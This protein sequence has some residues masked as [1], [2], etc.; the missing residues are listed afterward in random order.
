M[1]KAVFLDRDGVINKIVYS[2]EFGIVDSPKN[3]AEFDLFDGVGEAVKFFKEI[4]FLVI[5]VSNQPGVAKGKMSLELLEEITKKMKRE[6]AQKGAYLDGVYYCLHHPDSS[7]VKIKKYLKNCNCRK[8]KP[9]L[10]LK[11][12][13]E[14]DIDLTKSYIVG[15]GLT[16]IQAGRQA[17]CRT[18]FLGNLKCEICREMAKQKIKPDYI[19]SDLSSAAR[20]IQKVENNKR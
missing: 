2:S 13:K 8:P 17:G 12:A 1:T 7:Q 4:G 3:P 18:I 20:I 11:A 19:V 6:L 10:L 14:L 5:I 16:D 9:G 15:D